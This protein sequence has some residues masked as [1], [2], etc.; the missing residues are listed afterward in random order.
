MILG[1]VVARMRDVPGW[2]P[3]NREYLTEDG[4]WVYDVSKAWLFGQ[5]DFCLAPEEKGTARYGKLRAEVVAEQNSTRERP[6]YTFIL[7][8]VPPPASAEKSAPDPS[9]RF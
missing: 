2:P 8:D 6:C 7:T 3:K 1:F 4:A 9:R 5:E